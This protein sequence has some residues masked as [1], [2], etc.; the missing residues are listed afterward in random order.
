MATDL[1]TIMINLLTKKNFCH[2]NSG[3]CKSD[4]NGSAGLFE[5]G[6]ASNIWRFKSSERWKRENSWTHGE[7]ILHHWNVGACSPVDT[8]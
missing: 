2:I 3:E 8:V 5:A 6:R 4:K 1:S 7:G